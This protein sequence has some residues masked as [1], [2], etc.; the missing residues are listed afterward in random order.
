MS[1]KRGKSSSAA[2]QGRWEAGLM[3]YTFEE[4]TWKANIQFVVEGDLLDE[5]HIK[6]LTNV[7]KIPQRRLFSYLHKDDLMAMVN[8]LGNPKNKKPPKLPQFYEITEIIFGLQ[9]AG[10]D[11]PLPLWAKLIKFGLVNIKDNDLHRREEMKNKE[12]KEKTGKGS[13]KKRPRS[14]SPGKSKGKKTPEPQLPKKDWSTLKKRGDDDDDN[15][16]IDDEPDDGPQHYI[17]VSGFKR[18]QLLPI[19]VELGINI[20]GIIRIES[21]S[22]DVL[23]NV[24]ETHKSSLN[25]DEEAQSAA[26][27]KQESAYKELA[28]FWKLLPVVLDRAPP[29]SRLQDLGIHKH[30]VTDSILPTDWEDQDNMIG[31]GTTLFEELA[32]KVYDSL[33]AQRQYLHYLKNLKLLHVPVYGE[34]PP[35]EQ[36][37]T[38]PEH[39]NVP[40]A[41]GKREKTKATLEPPGAAEEVV[42]PVV[43]PLRQ[44]VDMRYYK[45][46]M[47]C[48]PMESVSVSLMMHCMLEQVVATETDK[49]PPSEKEPETRSDGIHLALAECIAD[50]LEGL[51]L[52]EEDEMVVEKD[53][54]SY[55]K[56]KEAFLEKNKKQEGPILLQFGDD[57]AVRTHHLKEFDGFKPIAAEESVLAQL[58]SSRLSSN[59]NASA[60]T[61]SERQA[62]L[63][64]LLQF[65]A[66]NDK[67][68]KLQAVSNT[69]IDQA[70][71]QFVFEN[72]ELSAVDKAGVIKAPVNKNVNLWD[73]PYMELVNKLKSMDSKLCQT[74]DD[75]SEP[76]KVDTSKLQS[77]VDDFV[78]PKRVLDSYCFSEAFKKTVLLQVLEEARQTYPCMDTYYH[79]RDN[80]MLVVF[81]NPMTEDLRGT[82]QWEASLHSDVGFR[83]YL[84]HVAGPIES[85]TKV[86]ED[87]Y[88]ADLVAM[89]MERAK[90][91][92]D[93]LA[94]GE[95][96]PPPTA[97][98]PR[99]KS[100]KKGSRRGSASR[101]SSKIGASEESQQFS[102]PFIHAGSLKAE[103]E[104]Q[105]KLKEEEE[106]QK[107]EKESKQSQRKK[108]VDRGKQAKSAASK[109]SQDGKRPGS[110]KR[111]RSGRKSKSRSRSR[112]SSRERL[113][114]PEVTEE[115]PK[116]PELPFTGYDVGNNLINIRG[117]ASF[118][119]PCDGGTIKSERIQYEQG[120]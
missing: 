67:S 12:D 47:N 30:I 112:S 105:N 96:T 70:L 100:P 32:C 84:E 115:A 31:F 9:N 95:S 102:S 25:L 8:E 86:E 45:D 80:S 11:I 79:K 90:Q 101:S 54:P 33:D 36:E 48:V 17:F 26:R 107:R 97:K 71:R 53:F 111:P 55:K 46:L 65:T 119:Y 73:D 93:A 85:W 82:I 42:P 6:A 114:K 77:E 22:Y 63:H 118:L 44:E 51:C 16:F 13:G 75:S 88:Q 94:A 50:A 43:P 74:T 29:T 4:E 116:I 99:S 19:L 72:M 58:P 113:A 15:K 37:V 20:N 66:T 56:K 23:K 64:E 89:E 81:H 62:R 83:N 49:V 76:P 24:D 68:D 18:A 38:Q 60:N 61:L 78:E 98:R 21:E 5:A 40:S 104:L 41:T 120:R 92:A 52:S 103:T 34:K 14:K 108:S 91:V 3:N 10:Q 110:G 35:S 39:R 1:K 87:K 27:I 2:G 59:I 109:T 117:N 28:L 57:A 69:E 7:V 106:R